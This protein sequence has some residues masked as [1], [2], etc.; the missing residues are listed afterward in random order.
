MKK[1]FK[2]IAIDADFLLFQC[3]EGAY[4]KDNTFDNEKV[5][6]KPFKVRLKQLVLDIQDEVAVELLGTAKLGK[7]IELLFSDPDTNFRYDIFADYKANR[8]GS[9]RSDTFYRLRK[10][11]LKKYDY[12]KDV[13]ADDR[14]ADALK[15]GFIVCSFD[16]DV[17]KTLAGTFFDTYHSRRGI[18]VTSELEAQRFLLTQSVMGDPTDNIL[19]IPRVAEKTAIKLLDEFG[20]D[21]QGVV[22]AYK[23]K[24]LVEKDAILTMRLVNLTQ[25]TPKKGVVLWTP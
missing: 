3:C 15:R 5:D 18:K 23:S 2:G 14:C 16:K 4:V 13:E 1:K 10:W 24:G 21:W 7:K 19:G 6:L 12:V 25:W 11:A 8:K 17:L 22:K 20:W 9:T